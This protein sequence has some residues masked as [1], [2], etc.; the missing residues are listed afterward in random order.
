MSVATYPG[1]GSSASGA[2]APPGGGG[3][4]K[5]PGGGKPDKTSAVYT[6][7]KGSTAKNFIIYWR[8][9]LAYSLVSSVC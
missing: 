5:P 4:G 7:P 8:K 9:C 2:G 3:G 6:Y 1:I